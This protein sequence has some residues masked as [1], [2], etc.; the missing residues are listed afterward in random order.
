MKETVQSAGAI[1][2]PNKGVFRF[3]VSLR[4]KEEAFSNEA[5][6]G[7]RLP[8]SLLTVRANRSLNIS[9]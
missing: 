7:E 4:C 5:L 8:K 3:K 9:F 6:T 2:K 1:E